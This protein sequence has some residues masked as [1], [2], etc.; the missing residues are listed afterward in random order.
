MTQFLIY[1]LILTK[2]NQT[3]AYVSVKNQYGNCYYVDCKIEC[4]Q[5]SLVMCVFFLW[6]CQRV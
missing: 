5:S 3:S 1:V 6:P 4:L 2:H